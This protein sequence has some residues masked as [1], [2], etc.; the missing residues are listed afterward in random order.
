MIFVKPV[1]HTFQSYSRGLVGIEDT[2]IF[3][4]AFPNTVAGFPAA[5]FTR[6]LQR[7]AVGIGIS[8]LLQTFIYGVFKFL[9]LRFNEEDTT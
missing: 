3:C 4:L 5:I 1:R 6:V 2:S 9:I 7:I 8:N